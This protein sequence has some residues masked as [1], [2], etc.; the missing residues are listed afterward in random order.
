MEHRPPFASYAALSLL[1]LIAVPI[2]YWSAFRIVIID[3]GDLLHN[4]ALIAIVLVLI[5]GIV[6]ER[7]V[8]KSIR[9][10]LRSPIWGLALG[11]FCAEVVMKLFFWIQ[12]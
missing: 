1:F 10:W 9:W 12:G 5:A 7:F 4:A 11:A 8:S 3:T 6:I 2:G